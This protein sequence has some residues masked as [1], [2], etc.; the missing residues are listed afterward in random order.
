MEVAMNKTAC[1]INACS[2]ANAAGELDV[3]S[4][5]KEFPILSNRNGWIFL[6]NAATSQKPKSVLRRIAQFYRKDCANAG[7]AAYRASTQATS[8][9]E[10]ARTKVAGFINADRS[11]VVFTSG[12][13]DSLNTV[14]LAW[15]LANLKTGDEIMV[16]YEDHKSSVLPWFNVQSLLGR[17]GIEIKIVPFEVHLE[18]DYELKSIR[19]RVSQRTRLLAMSHVH[20]LYGLDMEV[21]RIREIVGKDVLI[22]LD[23]SQSIGHRRVDVKELGVDFVSFSGHKMFAA[24]GVGVLW[25]S[26]ALHGELHAIKSGGK[27]PGYIGEEFQSSASSLVERLECGTQDIPAIISLSAAIDFIEKLG[28]QRIEKRVSELTH[29]LYDVLKTF[30]GVDFAP[31]FGRCGCPV[32]YGIFSFRFEQIATSDLAFLLD[33][34]NI[35]IRTGDHCLSSR[36]QGDDYA[37]VSLHVYNTKAEIDRLIEVLRV[38][39]T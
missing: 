5:R 20:H 24:N 31:G 22:S 23:A 14:A 32:G 17:F 4:I 10:A 35:Q 21:E 39:L 11:E 34:E 8:A 7:R 38:N 29:Y 1:S 19:E 9:I 13:T 15:G 16:C 6:D 28:L 27:T 18:G 30:P 36:H 37:R 12:A 33:G 2:P 26:S 3:D 25:V